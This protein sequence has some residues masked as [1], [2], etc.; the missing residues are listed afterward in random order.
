MGSEHIGGL[1]ERRPHVARDGQLHSAQA[2]E[3]IHRSKRPE[4]TIGGRRAAQRDDYAPGAHLH[5]GGDQLT[6]SGGGRSHR[7]VALRPAHERDPR[8]TRHLDDGGAPM[9]PPGSLH[10]ISQRACDDS[11]LVGS[12]EHVE[13]ALTSI[14]ER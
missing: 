2:G 4:A 13:G 8:R 7:I 11:G 1:Q 9:E 5:R 3:R 6:G 14:R 12:T 10:R